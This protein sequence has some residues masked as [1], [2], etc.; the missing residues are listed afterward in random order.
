[1][2]AQTQRCLMWIGRTAFA[3]SWTSRKMRTVASS[4]AATSSW[5]PW[6]AA[7]CGTWTT[8]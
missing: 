4:C 2:D 8:R 6:R 7:W 1:C 3:A 5:T